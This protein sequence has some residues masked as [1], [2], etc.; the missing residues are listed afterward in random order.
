MAIGR[1]AA[2][3]LTIVF[4]MGLAGYW[5]VIP[6]A[7]AQIVALAWTNNSVTLSFDTVSNQVYSVW[8]NGSLDAGS[9]AL[10]TNLLGTGSAATVTAPFSP[11]A[12]RFF[13][14]SQTIASNTEAG[15]TFAADATS[16]PP[17]LQNV[18]TNFWWLGYNLSKFKWEGGYA[19]APPDDRYVSIINNTNTLIGS[20]TGDP[21]AI[22]FRYDGQDIAFLT[23]NVSDWTLVVDGSI[24]G[25][26]LHNTNQ[27]S[28]LILH[29][30]T[31]RTR[32]IELHAGQ[33]LTLEY[34]VFPV[35]NSISLPNPSQLKVLDLGDSFSEYEEPGDWSLTEIGYYPF[36]MH[37]L[38]PRIE[39][40][41]ASAGGTGF[42][43]TNRNYGGPMNYNG[44]AP[45]FQVRIGWCAAYSNCVPDV[46]LFQCSDNDTAAHVPNLTIAAYQL[47]VSNCL[48][49]AKAAWPGARLVIAGPNIWHDYDPWA[50]S[51]HDVCQA[52]CAAFGADFIDWIGPNGSSPWLYGDWAG[53]PGNNTTYICSD[54]T[55]PNLLGGR[56]L[57]DNMLIAFYQL[58]IIAPP[59]TYGF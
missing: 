26:T 32:S 5:A 19:K 43:A 17:A 41:Q 46:V 12:C 27:Y 28:R 48:A 7:P 3:N 36:W 30:P 25:N 6:S 55:H 51:L 24:V 14:T 18:P 16:L 33:Q 59:A 58:G 57:A 35:T 10:Q 42:V 39:M 34:C 47:A 8:N 40:W 21:G 53:N 2:R 22:A 23:Y 52:E 38:D 4:C 31:P 9:W 54:H 50:V 56:F 13:R 15:I 37:L 20:W 1:W 11:P 44:Y 29:F 45:S 49:Q